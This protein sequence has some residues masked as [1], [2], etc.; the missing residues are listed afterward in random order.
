RGVTEC[1]SKTRGAAMRH[2]KTA[3]AALRLAPLGGGSAAIFVSAPA[4]AQTTVKLELWSRQDPS[5]PLRPVN[6]VKAADRLNKE[7]AAEGSGKR[8]KV[9]GHES[10]P[11]GFA[12]DC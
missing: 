11:P 10:P 3:M 7:L 12:H 8:G 1:V 5:G 9:G 6:V 2:V 4:P